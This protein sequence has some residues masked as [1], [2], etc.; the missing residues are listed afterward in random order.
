VGGSYLVALIACIAGAYAPAFGRLP[1]FTIVALILLGAEAA[2]KRGGRPEDKLGVRLTLL[3]TACSFGIYAYVRL[4]APFDAWVLEALLG[5]PVLLALTLALFGPLAFLFVRRVLRW[6]HGLRTAAVVVTLF[7]SGLVGLAVRRAAL[8]PDS[9]DCTEPYPVVAILPPQA[10]LGGLP[11]PG[12]HNIAV[13]GV[14]FTSVCSG[15]RCR[16]ALGNAPLQSPDAVGSRARVSFDPHD[17]IEIRHDPQGDEWMVV[18]RPAIGWPRRCQVVKGPGLDR[19]RSLRPV[20]L[21][22]RLSPARDWIAAAALGILVALVELARGAR[23]LRWLRQLEG[24]VPALVDRDGWLIFRDNTPPMRLR[25]GPFVTGRVMLLFGARRRDSAY[26]AA[27]HREVL[28]V[29]P[30]RL[31][32]A[33]RCVRVEAACHDA[34]AL[35]AVALTAAPLCVSAWLGFLR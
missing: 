12:T 26:R 5:F 18:P 1:P 13:A 34:M 20:D 29:I 32:D 10:P 11:P 25:R 2:P 22:A 16:G 17:L 19:S 23:C 21:A 31:A 24:A 9:L 35:G 6:A 4:T 28:E 8:L 27:D 3:G 14:Y 33:L 7:T 15:T 30:G